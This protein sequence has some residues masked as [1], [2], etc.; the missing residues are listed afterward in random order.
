MARSDKSLLEEIFFEFG[1]EFQAQSVTSLSKEGTLEIHKLKESFERDIF[2]VYTLIAFPSPETSPM[3]H[4]LQQS[5][6]EYISD[7]LLKAITGK[8]LQ[9]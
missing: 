5:R 6:R 3:N 1:H 4:L 7:L 9:Y 8:N 2:Q